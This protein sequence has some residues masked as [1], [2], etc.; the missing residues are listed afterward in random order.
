MIKNE[1]ITQPKV[2]IIIPVYN[3]S[4]YVALA[5]ESALRQTY[6]NIEII[7]VNDGSTDDTDA[8]CKKYGNKIVYLPKENGGVST[9]LNYGIKNMTGEYFSWLSHDDLYY[10]EKIQTEIDYLN[11]HSLLSKRA[12][13]YSNYS[14]MDGEGN[15]YQDIIYNTY[16]LN[17]YDDFSLLKMAING[18]SLLIPKKAFDECGEFDPN[19]RC[20]QDY[21][22][23]L[24]MLKKGYRFIHIPKSLVVTRLHSLQV[25]NTS[26]KVRTEGNKFW[27]DL[28]KSYNK[29]DI[30]KM[31]D[32][33][34]AFYNSL[35]NQFDQGPYDEAIEYS[36][37]QM[38]EIEKSNNKKIDN[39]RISG[40][41]YNI[42]DIEEFNET[43]KSMINQTHRFDEIYAIC[44]KHDKKQIE[45]VTDKKIK[46]FD[47]SDTNQSKALNEII[48]SDKLDYI[49]FIKSGDVL[50]KE[51]NDVGL[52]KIVSSELVFFHSSYN[53]KVE[54]DTKKVDMSL[55]NGFITPILINKHDICYSSAIFDL[56]Y[57]K[58]NKIKF[59]EE[60]KHGFIESFAINVLKD[61][62]IISDKDPL[63]TTKEVVDNRTDIYKEF[64]NDKYFD[65]YNEELDKLKDFSDG[66][67]VKDDIVISDEHLEELARYSFMLTKEFRVVSKIRNIGRKATFRKE[68]ET[69]KISYKRLKYGILNKTYNKLSNIKN[70]RK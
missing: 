41:I 31:Y 9:A 66:K 44:S 37:K 30:I 35:Y 47:I 34:Y 24:R 28:I 62:N 23:W 27:I 42:D 22:L 14:I 12:I 18:L 64:I 36:L 49:S 26:P 11:E 46:I 13:L 19:L 61:K 43:Y 59:N 39:S 58:K 20:V 57:I 68:Q 8:I 1:D 5:I 52:K 21:E 3:G 10:P 51:R 38:K 15:P 7:V 53:I 4:N 63:V 17:K 33:E 70:R 67:E 65:K 6:K 25:T 55:V 45:N 69:Y 32:S 40:V 50:I 56:N 60:L 29:K 48:K 54:S 16:D 2:S